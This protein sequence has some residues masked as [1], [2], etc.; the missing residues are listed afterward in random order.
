MPTMAPTA[1]IS[2]AGEGKERFVLEFA[3][4]LLSNSVQVWLDEWELG[5]TRYL[6][7]S[8]IRASGTPTR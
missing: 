7:A 6:S 8:S 2:H 5:A 3:S 4:Q 1:F